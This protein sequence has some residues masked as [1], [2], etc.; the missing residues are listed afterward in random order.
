M[1][2]VFVWNNNQITTKIASRMHYTAAA[3]EVVGHVSMHIDDDFL[4]VVDEETGFGFDDGHV[5]WLP[6]GTPETGKRRGPEVREKM[7]ADLGPNFLADLTFE[8]YAPDHVIRIPNPP[9]AYLNRMRSMRARHE[10]LKNGEVQH[11]DFHRKN[12]SRVV[13]RVLR[14]GW[15]K[16]GGNFKYGQVVRGLW[17]PLMVKR[18]AIDLVG[19][20]GLNQ[21]AHALTWHEFLWEMVQQKAVMPETANLMAHFKRRA[22]NRGS[23]Q[24]DARFQF[25]GAQ[26]FG[27]GLA[28]GVK[29]E[30]NMPAELFLYTDLKARG[31]D[32]EVAMDIFVGGLS[33]K[34]GDKPT[35]VIER[36]ARKFIRLSMQ[37][38]KVDWSLVKGGMK[39]TGKR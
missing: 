38:A 5:S 32:E 8:N 14:N 33:L 28:S 1:T 15:K 24:A 39:K 27:K 37:V 13:S 4:P 11:Y 6:A 29:G 20:P 2:T 7:A 21:P 26:R 9:L 19:G 36:A 23:S 22:D 35:E 12:C 30:E 25:K 10:E 16:T 18:L 31:V 17:T 3:K 34:M